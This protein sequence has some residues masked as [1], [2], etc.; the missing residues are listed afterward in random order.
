V[1]WFRVVVVVVV[2]EVLLSLMR[3]RWEGL[4]VGVV[5]LG[6]WFSS[7]PVESLGVLFL[8]SFPADVARREVVKVVGR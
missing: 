6:S 7:I 4:D 8:F 3:F 2:L 5:C 1:F